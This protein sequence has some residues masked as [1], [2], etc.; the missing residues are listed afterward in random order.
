M[1]PAVLEEAATG[2]VRPSP[3][4][5]NPCPSFQPI[6]SSSRFPIPV[7]AAG[8]GAGRRRASFREMRLPREAPLQS[9]SLAQLRV[10]QLHLKQEQEEQRQHRAGTWR[11]GPTG[12]STGARLAQH[13]LCL[14]VCRVSLD[15]S[16]HV[17]C[18]SVAPLMDAAKA[19]PGVPM[20]RDGRP[21][22]NGD[23]NDKED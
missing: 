12:A 23:F 10:Q 13:Y 14:E 16:V 19:A 20:R 3:C 21:L 7:T 6:F 22:Y 17:V 1:S 15:G 4:F 2:S 9:S 8:G 5:R 11:P 18:R